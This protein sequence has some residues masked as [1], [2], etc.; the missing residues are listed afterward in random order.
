LIKSASSKEEFKCFLAIE[1]TSADS[2]DEFQLVDQDRL[3]QL[4]DLVVDAKGVSLGAAAD[5]SMR[6][7]RSATFSRLAS[8][9]GAEG[10][11]AGGFLKRRG[12][13]PAFSWL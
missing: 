1:T 11:V 13:L 6:S 8:G 4:T 12:V 3:F 10:A 9:I 7:S 5:S 2:R